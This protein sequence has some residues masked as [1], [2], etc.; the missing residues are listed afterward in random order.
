MKMKVKTWIFAL[1]GSLL[2]TGCA[3]RLPEDELSRVAARLDQYVMNDAMTQSEM[4]IV[5]KFRL[6]LLYM[7]HYLILYRI[8]NQPGYEKIEKVFI[9]DCK[10]WDRK[11][12]AEAEKPSEFEGGSRAPLDRNLRMADFVQR[13]IDELRNKWRKP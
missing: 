7:E 13:R 1:T 8:W 9:E 11:A 2:L 4:N 6:D 3:A 12:K 10:A 5:S